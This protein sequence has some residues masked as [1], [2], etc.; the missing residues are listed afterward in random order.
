M[1]KLPQQG[2]A[3]YFTTPFCYSKLKQFP[4][5]LEN[6]KCFNYQISKT[7]NLGIGPNQKRQ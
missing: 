3:T 6:T 5:T 1:S 7:N 2:T 4:S